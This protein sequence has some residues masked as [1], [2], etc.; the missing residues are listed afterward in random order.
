MTFNDNA[1]IGGG[2]ASKRGR[3]TGIAVGGGGLGVVAL[4]ILS[5]I[6]GVDLTG[7][8]GGGGPQP[9]GS[10]LENCQTGADANANIDCRM[11]GA[12]ASLETY[13]AAELPALG[14]DYQSPQDLALFTDSVNTGCGAA[15]SATGPF[16]CP[17]DATIYIDTAFYDE[18]RTRFGSS[19]GPLAEMYVVAHEWGHHIQNVTG[20][21]EASQDGRTG[22]GSNAVRVE[23]Q[24]DC[25]AGAWAA[26]ASTTE[27]AGG[28]PFLEPITQAQ[29]TDALSAASA[30]GD[31]RIQQATQGQVN[32]E[33]W[34]HGSS[35]QRQR[36]FLTGFEQGADGC[37]TF[38][39]GDAAL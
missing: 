35:E 18:L 2:R 36:W 23:L 1:N 7:L 26:A 9:T 6:L 17:P 27:D 30:V 34:T 25:Y 33:G 20:V 14:V 39:P 16:Y 5:Q 22:A 32:P 12:A 29:I 37:D 38:K 13:W 31:D 4:I 24:A 10:S 21:L 19:G 15:S 8:A 28:V 3:N 11:K